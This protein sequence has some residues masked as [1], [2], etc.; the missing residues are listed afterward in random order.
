MILFLNADGRTDEFDHNREF[1]GSSFFGNQWNRH[2][3][4]CTDEFKV[5]ISRNRGFM[6]SSFLEISEI[7]TLTD[8]HDRGF[9]GF[10]FGN[11]WNRHLNRCTDKLS[12][13][14]G[15]FFLGISGIVTLT[16]EFA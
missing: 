11:Q 15:F 13:D 9:V 3:N 4:R 6:D 16:N 1:V 10:F 8:S 5:M 2:L 7:I 12:R 14:C